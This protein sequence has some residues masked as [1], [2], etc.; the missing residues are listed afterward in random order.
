MGSTI[1]LINIIRERPSAGSARA[2]PSGRGSLPSALEG[3]LQLRRWLAD[4]RG[5]G[6]C[7]RGPPLAPGAEDPESALVRLAAHLLA[8][9]RREASAGGAAAGAGGPQPH[10]GHAKMRFKMAA[11]QTQ[12]R[13]VDEA[14]CLWLALKLHGEQVAVPGAERVAAVAGARKVQLMR[15]EAQIAAALQWKLLDGFLPAAAGA[16]GA[17]SPCAAC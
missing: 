14:A 7:A 11:R 16:G 10:A 1:F 12:G 13:T 15:A 2:G 9:Y 8:R 6:A 3:D 5:F 17:G 4:L